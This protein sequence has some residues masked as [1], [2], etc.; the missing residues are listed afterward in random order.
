VLTG[1]RAPTWV[2]ALG[3]LDA[4]HIDAHDRIRLALATHY[5]K[6]AAVCGHTVFLHDGV[7]RTLASPRC[8]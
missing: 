6:V 4:W 5:R 3:H 8:R 2:V 7:R 1:P